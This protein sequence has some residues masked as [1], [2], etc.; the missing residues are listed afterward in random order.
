MTTATDTAR[1]GESTNYVTPNAAGTSKPKR[2]NNPAAAQATA[3]T[4]KK[5]LVDKAIHEVTSDASNVA[6]ALSM[7][8]YGITDRL[9]P[10][11]GGI[12]L[13]GDEK[14]AARRDAALPLF[15]GP[16]IPLRG[17]TVIHETPS[18]L[19]GPMA[20]G[21]AAPV[22]GSRKRRTTAASQARQPI[23]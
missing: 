14:Y 7:T 3:A 9:N 20:R 2:I 11:G 15:A 1:K 4:K 12:C 16:T 19:L 22:A 5:S 13:G 21:L 23:S 18:V 6:S 17:A 10:F 8:T